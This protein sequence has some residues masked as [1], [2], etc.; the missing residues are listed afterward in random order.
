MLLSAPFAPMSP[1][2]A[3]TYQLCPRMELLNH[4]Y[5]EGKFSEV[6]HKGQALHGVLAYACQQ[7]Q[8]TAMWPGMDELLPKLTALLADLPKNATPPEQG[9]SQEQRLHRWVAETQDAVA[10]FVSFMAQQK[11]VQVVSSEEWVK[12][13]LTQLTGTVRVTGRLDLLLRVEG[14][15]WVLDFKT[16]KTPKQEWTHGPMAMALYVRAVQEDYPTETVHAF[17]FYPATQ[18]LVPYDTAQVGQ[19]LQHLYG[20]GIQHFTETEWQALTGEHCQWCDHFRRCMEMDKADQNIS[21]EN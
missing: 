11:G 2:V 8:K 20:L 17:E 14:E 16:G 6:L 12:V 13:D 15:L 18:T 7:Y 9:E 1:S 21:E 10:G 19:H 5:V 4:Y 3:E